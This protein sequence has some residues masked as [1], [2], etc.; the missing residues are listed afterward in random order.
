MKNLSIVILC[1]ARLAI[2]VLWIGMIFVHYNHAVNNNTLNQPAVTLIPGT[3]EPADRP[4]PTE[5]TGFYDVPQDGEKVGV[6]G[7]AVIKSDIVGVRNYEKQFPLLI[8]GAYKSIFDVVKQELERGA[9]PN[10][11]SFEGGTA[12]EYGGRNGDDTDQLKIFDLLIDYGAR[13][14]LGDV[15]GYMAIH[16]TPTVQDLRRRNH[17]VAVLLKHGARVED[18]TKLEESSTKVE[19]QR[20]AARNYNTLEILVNN[21][22]RLGVVDMLMRWGWL[23]VKPLRERVRAYAYDLGL[24][25]IAGEFDTYDLVLLPFKNEEKIKL[26]QSESEKMR[27]ALLK[28]GGDEGLREVE[29]D[30]DYGVMK[31]GNVSVPL[32]YGMT[33]LML[34]VLKGS[35]VRIE[36]ILSSAPYQLELKSDDAYKRTALLMAVLQQNVDIVKSL[37]KAGARIDAVDY[38]GGNALHLAARIGDLS[39]QKKITPLLVSA[40]CLF[41]AGDVRGETVLHR[42][43]RLRDAVYIEYLMQTYKNVLDLSIKNKEGLTAYGLAKKLGLHDSMRSL[44]E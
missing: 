27:A 28:Y 34:A 37:L 23:H 26:F 22:D 32:Y 6:S 42:A 18:M 36:S 1:V 14:R 9:D 2:V 25:D 41:N 11:K 20:H 17:Y 24:R 29:F 5:H 16:M 4:E 43:V 39:I 13:V 12:L 15:G 7:I 3:Y 21:Y 31:V 40:G 19:G 33:P 35:I 10:V 44:M 30:G 38:Q 8:E